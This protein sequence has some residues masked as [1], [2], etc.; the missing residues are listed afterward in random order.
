MG[1]ERLNALSLAYTD[2]GIFL[3]YDKIINIYESKYTRRMLSINP[4][5]E[6]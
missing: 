2:R 5:S 1:K 4:L 3:D 6:N